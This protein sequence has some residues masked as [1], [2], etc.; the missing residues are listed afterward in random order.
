LEKAFAAH[1]VQLQFIGVDPAFDSL[2]GDPRF[3]DLMRRLRL[4]PA[5]AESRNP[6]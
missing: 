2:R 4:S 3:A 5:V 6:R 1:D